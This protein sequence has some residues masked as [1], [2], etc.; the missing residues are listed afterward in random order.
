M[1][2]S[3]RSIKIKYDSGYDTSGSK[4]MKNRE[5]QED[6]IFAL[7]SPQRSQSLAL[8]ATAYEP[9]PPS[10]WGTWMTRI[11]RIFTDYPL[12]SAS[13]AH[14]VFDRNPSAYVSVL[15]LIFSRKTQEALAR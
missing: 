6:E 9:A 8:L 13:S 2:N 1:E 4:M 7:K 3:T 14:S 5:M 15:R 10:R 11:G 12:V